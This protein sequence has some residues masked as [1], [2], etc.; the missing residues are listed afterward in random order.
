MARHRAEL[1]LAVC[2]CAL[3][4]STLACSYPE[5]CGRFVAANRIARGRDHLP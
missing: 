1:N 5:L 3:V 2:V 4:I